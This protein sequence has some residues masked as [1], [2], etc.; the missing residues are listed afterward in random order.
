MFSLI[1]KIY[2]TIRLQNF[3]FSNNANLSAF[4]GRHSLCKPIDQNITKMEENQNTQ[5]QAL[6][7][8]EKTQS[9]STEEQIGDE[10][11]V[12]QCQEQLTEE[13]AKYMRLYADFD[14]FKKRTQKEKADFFKY[15]NEDTLSSMLPIL[16]DFERA[17][18]QLELEG[19]DP[20]SLEGIKLIYNK[21]FNTL[22]EKGLQKIEVQKGDDFDVETQE[23]ITQ[24]ETEDPD[25]KNKVVDIIETGYTLGDKVIRYTKV[26]TGK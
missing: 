20:Q 2:K 6:E 9:V 19:K 1:F 15:A 7:N 25:M 14:N 12:S 26:V 17:M 5:E 11:E 18:H 23:A 13:K 21:L 3:I 22:K 24:I 16:D 8:E 10:K 4:L